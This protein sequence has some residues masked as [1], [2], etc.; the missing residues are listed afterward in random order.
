MGKIVEQVFPGATAEV[1]VINDHIRHSGGRGHGPMDAAG[2]DIKVHVDPQR[3]T[4]AFDSI[5]DVLRLVVIFYNKKHAEQSAPLKGELAEIDRR[6]N[7]SDRRLG[8]GGS[9]NVEEPTST[10]GWRRWT[11][12]GVISRSSLCR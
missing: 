1:G 6:V 2:D 3:K 11:F 10:P 4:M 9:P 8:G 7:E 5:D 12:E